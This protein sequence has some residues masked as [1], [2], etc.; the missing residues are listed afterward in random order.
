[1][2]EEIQL[3]TSSRGILTI[4]KGYKRFIFFLLA[5]FLA[6]HCFASNT[7][8]QYR[9]S[10]LDMESGLPNN[11]VFTLAQDYLGY[12]WIGTFGGLA[13]YDGKK[14]VS[15]K[16]NPSEP[17]SITSSVIF[18]ILE[19]SQQRLWVGTDGGGLNLYQRDTDS[20]IAKRYSA[21]DPTS[22]SSDQVFT[23]FEDSSGTIWVGTGGGGLNRMVDDNHFITY[24]ANP[25]SKRSLQS[26]TIREII[27]D[28]RGSIWIGTDGGGLATYL[29]EEDSFVSFFYQPPLENQVT[30][31]AKNNSGESLQSTNSPLGSSVKALYEDSR[32]ILWVGF[33]GAGLAIFDPIRKEFT[34]INLP[35]IEDDPISVRTIKEDRYGRIWVGTDGDGLSILEIE[36]NPT[37]HGI[38]PKNITHLTSDPTLEYSLSSDKIRDVFIDMT[39]LVWIGLRDGGLN[40]FNPLSFSFHNLSSDSES[41]Y[42]LSGNTIRKILEAP[43]GDIWI[44]TDGNG[45]NHYDP[46]TKEITWPL[47]HLSEPFDVSS[48]TY[49]LFIDGGILWIGTDDAGVYAYNMEENK[50]TSHFQRNDDS[51]LSS[52]A[53]WDIFKDSY[54]YLWFGT[55]GG[56]LNRFDPESQT[57][58]VFTFDTRDPCSI[59]GNSVRII[60]EDHKRNLWIGTWDGGLNLYRR[61]T[62]DFVRFHSIPGNSK[63]LSDN[64]VNTIFEDSK[65]VLWIGTA[66][67]GLNRF[68]V[69]DETFTNWNQSDGLSSDNI[70]GILEDANGYLWLTSDNGLT[71]FNSITGECVK[72]YREDGLQGN[73]FMRHAY[74]TASDGT[75]Y[76]GGTK[77]VTYF[78][79]TT[80]LPR[81]VDSPFLVTGLKIQ[82]KNVTVGP[83]Q[84]ENPEKFRL[85]LDRPLYEN[86]VVHLAP[87]DSFITFT[88]ALFDF[89]NPGRN[90]YAVMLEGQDADWTNLGNQNSITFP[91]LPPGTYILR[92][93][94]THYNGIVHSF[95]QKVTIQVDKFFYQRWYAI[96]GAVLLLMLI[97]FLLVRIRLQKLHA[98]NAELREYSIYIQDAREQQRKEIA[99]EIHDQLGQILT[100]LKFDAFWLRNAMKTSSDV[101]PEMVERTNEMVNV[102]DSA[103]DSVKNISTRLRP[104]ALDSLGFSEALQWQAMEFQQRTGISCKV[105]SSIEAEQLPQEVSTTLYRIL[106]ELL[107]NVIRHAQATEVSIIFHI[108]DSDYYL[109]VSDNGIGCTAKAIKSKT[110]FGFISIR[111]RCESLGGMVR[112]SS[113]A[114][115]ENTWLVKWEHY[116]ERSIPE[117]E[118][119]QGTTVEI[120]IPLRSVAMYYKAS[121]TNEL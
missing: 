118:H 48:L 81:E 89:V 115:R 104:S 32:N 97:L 45:L 26:N 94:A 7:I 44:A 49:S 90:E 30:S 91:I 101:L 4:S 76:V 11:S 66:G 29:P 31:F 102:M 52:N 38:N 35:G 20:F 34:S 12:M 14:F 111:E 99:R 51:H 93:R 10:S 79:P 116:T 27:Q 61:E 87:T 96:L 78:N 39:G 69:T 15:Y 77:G 23:L 68:D 92:I 1:M 64:S 13:R 58:K 88:F 108:T 28:H 100:S 37:G 53:V 50:I 121:E 57:F 65:G 55:E 95:E 119:N 62:E 109:R 105:E 47:T 112:I 24:L 70:L 17:G 82:N 21:D 60:F 40:L 98:K 114:M 85:L 103:L 117:V 59:L 120:L 41:P 16:P 46:K 56:G 86:P 8:N 3:K 22:I 67:G 73:E 33:E 84:L 113:S 18:D 72:F 6:G 2:G 110:A 9:F 43:D 36:N 54:D 80:I 106:Q 71:R 75:F 63:T 74:L 19:D 5:I 83:L 42:R 25:L 107:T